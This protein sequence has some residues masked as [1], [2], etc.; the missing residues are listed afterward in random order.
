[1]NEIG[2]Q[3]KIDIITYSDDPAEFIINAMSPAEIISV[4]VDEEKHRATVTVSKDQQSI[5]I[6]R[7]G[8]NVRLA[9][10]LTGYEID[11]EAGEEVPEE[12]KPGPR[13]NVEDSLFSAIEES[14][15]GEE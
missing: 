3:E 13:K 9:S 15:Q 14:S 7:S 5:A 11:I 2:D 1:M 6:G 8:Q 12:T 10:R 4:R